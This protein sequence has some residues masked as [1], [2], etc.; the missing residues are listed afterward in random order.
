MLLQIGGQGGQ[1]SRAARAVVCAEPGPAH[2]RIQPLRPAPRQLPPHPASCPRTQPTQADAQH[3]HQQPHHRTCTSSHTTGKTVQKSTVM[4]RSMRRLVCAP[5]SR[6][7]RMPALYMCQSCGGGG[8]GGGGG[9]RG[10]AE[11]DE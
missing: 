3:L 11:A 2:R 7:S 10:G 1:R 6:A 5:S 9:G 4:L 8:G